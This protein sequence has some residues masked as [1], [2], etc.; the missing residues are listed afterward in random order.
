MNAHFNYLIPVLGGKEIQTFFL[1]L[2]CKVGN[3]FVTPREI[4]GFKSILR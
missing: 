3:T 1:Q 2:L 4:Y